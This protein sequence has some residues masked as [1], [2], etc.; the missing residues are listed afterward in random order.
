MKMDFG[1]TAADYM[2]A[3]TS[4]SCAAGTTPTEYA[5]SSQC[6]LHFKGALLLQPLCTK[7]PGNSLVGTKQWLPKHEKVLWFF[8]ALLKQ[9][10]G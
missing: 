7:W 6:L 1:V 3:W 9:L 10:C 5:Y 4:Q 8:S 2:P